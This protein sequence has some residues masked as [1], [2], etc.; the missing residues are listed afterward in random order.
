MSEFAKSKTCAEMTHDE[1]LTGKWVPAELLKANDLFAKKLNQKYESLFLSM[2]FCQSSNCFMKSACKELKKQLE[3]KTQEITLLRKGLTENE[4]FFKIVKK[5]WKEAGYGN[6]TEDEKK[7]TITQ[8]LK[9]YKKLEG[10]IAEAQK[11]LNEYPVNPPRHQK[12]YID[13]WLERLRAILREGE[14]K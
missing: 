6:L 5:V 14:K 11:I 3:A 13:R 9:D 12:I 4:W 7:W 8:F 2:V 1:I 10:Q